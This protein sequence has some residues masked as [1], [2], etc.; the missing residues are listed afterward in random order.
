MFTHFADF[1]S[2]PIIENNRGKKELI[3]KLN[4][5]VAFEVETGN[6]K[7]LDIKVDMETID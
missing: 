1:F 2:F 3:K 7:N 4:V 6:T 5:S